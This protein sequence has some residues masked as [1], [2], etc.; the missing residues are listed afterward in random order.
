MSMDRAI[1]H[2]DMDAFFASVEQL[3]FPFLR[4]KPVLVGGDGPRGVVAA[5]SYE[6]RVFGCHS[7]LPMVIAKRRCPH[8]VVMPVRSNRYHQLSK[9][10]FTIF[11]SFTPILQ[12][13]S[14]DEAFLDVTGSKRLHGCAKT[15]AQKIKHKIFNE[16]HLTVSVGVGPNMFLAKL[17]SG[18]EKP[19]GLTVMDPEDI[20]QRLAPLPVNRLWG[21]GPATG[22]KLARLGVQTFGQLQAMSV[23]VLESH[24]GIQG[25]RMAQLANG[26]D[27]RSVIPDRRAKSLSQEHTFAKDVEHPEAV[28]AV[29]LDQVETVGRRLRRAG[30]CAQRITLK[31]RY[32]QFQTIT[33]S[34]KLNESTDSF[35]SLWLVAV[36]LFDHWQRSSY[37]PV[38]LIGFGTAGLTH[39]GDQMGL[40][41][42]AS[43]NRRDNL[44]QVTDQIQAKYGS[45]SI[46][47][48]L[49]VLRGK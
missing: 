47:R 33:R 28:R 13:L 5:A 25:R 23:K 41:T 26:I 27:H 48:G 21:V 42:Q 8:A 44:D 7:A 19:D 22:Q 6:A 43:D 12:P 45:K 36:N 14:I 34:S 18:L 10:V 2:A 20:Q 15:I 38:R 3:D 17:A 11:E 31:I 37:Q 9:Q 39:A 46:G 30:L 29:L 1:L 49:G 4:N 24:F 16:L 40:F 35:E 32:G